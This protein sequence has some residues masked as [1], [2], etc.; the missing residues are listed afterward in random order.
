MAREMA[1]E[2]VGQIRAGAT[3]F[4]NESREKVRQVERSFEQ[5]VRE[6]PLKSMLIAAGVG[7]LFGRFWMRR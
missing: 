3:D 6:K 7:M 1:Q 2:K 4:T 5:Y